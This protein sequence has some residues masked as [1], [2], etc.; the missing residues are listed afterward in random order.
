MKRT[1][2]G[3][4]FGPPC[5]CRYMAWRTCLNL[6]FNLLQN[7]RSQ[8]ILQVTIF[9]ATDSLLASQFYFKLCC[10]LTY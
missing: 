6:T 4:I 10:L 3:A 9:L 1:I 2:N 7:L 5:A 8:G